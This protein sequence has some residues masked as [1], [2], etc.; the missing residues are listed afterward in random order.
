MD[1]LT[2]PRR[3]EFNLESLNHLNTTRKWTMFLA[4]MGFIWLALLIIFTLTIGAFMPFMSTETGFGSLETGFV[5]GILIVF[6]IIYF[7]PLLY[8]YKFSMYSK[9]AFISL[10]PMEVTQSMRYLKAFFRY[11]G[12]M[13]IIIIAV[14][15]VAFLFGGLAAMIFSQQ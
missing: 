1:P 4:I 6:A 5:A 10:D 12:I 11:M 2:E 15:L 7:F 13:T 3:L 14:Y 9:R 8:L